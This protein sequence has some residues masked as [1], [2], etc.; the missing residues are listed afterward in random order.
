MRVRAPVR[1]REERARVGRGRNPPSG[2]ESEPDELAHHLCCFR[3]RCVPRALFKATIE[4]MVPAKGDRVLDAQNV[5]STPVL[6]KLA[7]TTP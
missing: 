6:I 5:M 3:F 2:A 7:W 4:S 1:A